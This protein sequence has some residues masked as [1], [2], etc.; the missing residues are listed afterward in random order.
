MFSLA[1]DGVNPLGWWKEHERMFPILAHVAKTVYTIPASSS[2]SE[3]TFSCAG[4]FVTTKRNR[5]GT[6]KLEDLVILKEN[7]ETIVSFKRDNPNMESSKD[8]ISFDKVQIECDG[9]QELEDD[10]DHELLCDNFD[11]DDD[12]DED[13]LADEEIIDE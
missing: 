9:H 13:I 8:R 12:D 4:N 5:L 7:Q 3:R 2:K 6:K 11:W 1:P 10:L